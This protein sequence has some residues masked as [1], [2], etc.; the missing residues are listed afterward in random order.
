VDSD[1][2]HPRKGRGKSQLGGCPVLPVLD[3]V[4]DLAP[5]TSVKFLRIFAFN[6]LI[7]GIW[8]TR[9]SINTAPFESVLSRIKQLK[10]GATVSLIRQNL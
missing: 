7:V 5:S 2:I 4:L 9:T 8:R 10:V 3:G 1:G 6:F